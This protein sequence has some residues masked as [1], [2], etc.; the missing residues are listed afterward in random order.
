M[1][2][3]KDFRVF[4]YYFRPIVSQLLEAKTIKLCN[5]MKAFWVSNGLERYVNTFNRD[6]G[7]YSND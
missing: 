7:N 6:P 2:I 1:K 3:Y 4:D 5:N